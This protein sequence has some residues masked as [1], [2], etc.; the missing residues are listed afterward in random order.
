MFL[1]IEKEDALSLRSGHLPDDGIMIVIQ[2]LDQNI[3]V[4]SNF[5]IGPGYLSSPIGRD[6]LL[7]DLRKSDRIYNFFHGL[8]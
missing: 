8:N 3:A 5:L 4:L 2:R 6:T 1:D 7:I